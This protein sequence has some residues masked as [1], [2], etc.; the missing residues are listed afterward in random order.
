MSKLDITQRLSAN[1]TI[2]DLSGKILIGETSIKFRTSLQQLMRGG[3][4][5]ILLNLSDISSIDSCGLGELVGGFV[6]A[7]KNG[8]KVKLLNLTARVSEI[9]MITKL[10]TVFEVYENEE[11]AVNS[12]QNVSENRELKQSAYATGK[13]DK[14]LLT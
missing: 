7:G 5:H 14:A 1:V 12:F 2:L 13:P 3:E 8:G 10:L 11:D 9:M 6:S 4:K